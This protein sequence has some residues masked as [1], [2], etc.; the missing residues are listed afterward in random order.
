M[1][2]V[3]DYLN[4]Y[5]YGTKPKN[6]ITEI[7]TTTTTENEGFEKIETIFHVKKHLISIDDLKFINLQPVHNIIPGPSRNAPPEFTKV[8][9][10]NLNKAQLN[11]ILSVKLKPIPVLQK[12]TFFPPRHPV[13]FELYNKFTPVPKN[14]G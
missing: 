3:F 10:C 12:Q 13:I 6:D 11:Q 5:L 2:I 4:Y 7:I 14:I 9:L 8:D 1:S